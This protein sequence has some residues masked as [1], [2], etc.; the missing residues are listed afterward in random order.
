MLG[1]S[2]G[3]MCDAC[4]RVGDLCPLSSNRVNCSRRARKRRM[5]VFKPAEDPNDEKSRSI[6]AA[7]ATFRN[8]ALADHVDKGPQI[9]GFIGILT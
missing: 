7:E 8:A 2:S 9:S 5:K 3:R 6:G 1:C 4:S